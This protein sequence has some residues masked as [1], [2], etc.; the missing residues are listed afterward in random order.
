[1]YSEKGISE[2]S[3][4]MTKHRQQIVSLYD[5]KSGKNAHKYKTHRNSLPYSLIF[6]SQNLCA[7]NGTKNTMFFLTI[8]SK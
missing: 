8:I 4:D 6:S 1:M 3:E 7:S 2:Q 5:E